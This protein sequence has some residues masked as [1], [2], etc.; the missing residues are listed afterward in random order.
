MILLILLVIVL[1]IKTIKQA[2]RINDLELSDD[3]EDTDTYL[4]SKQN[5]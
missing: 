4:Q 3:W 2:I 1:I 5:K